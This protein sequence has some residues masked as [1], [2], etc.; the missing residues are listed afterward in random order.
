MLLRLEFE[1][2]EDKFKTAICC[3]IKKLFDSDITP[4]EIMDFGLDYVVPAQD[5][6]SMIAG[7]CLA[8][9]VDSEQ[10]KFI[11]IS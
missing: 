10:C 3:S 7:S 5:I 8:E 4:D 11:R 2:D 1:V 6:K 9:I